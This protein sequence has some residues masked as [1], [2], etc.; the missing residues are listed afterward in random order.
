MLGSLLRK[1]GSMLPRFLGEHKI[2]LQISLR[3]GGLVS[4]Y[5][6]WTDVLIYEVYG[7]ME[8]YLT[9]GGQN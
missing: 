3:I 5:G 7:L 9:Y 8:A 2:A 4:F 1:L 6:Y